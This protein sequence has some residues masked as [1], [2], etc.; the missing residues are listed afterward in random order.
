MSDQ[1]LI[2]VLDMNGN[3]SAFN[4]SDVLFFWQKSARNI[5]RPCTQVVYSSPIRKHALGE[6]VPL[7]SMASRIQK[8]GMLEGLIERGWHISHSQA[9][10]VAP[11]L[12]D[13]Q[14]L[15]SDAVPEMKFVTLHRAYTAARVD[16]RVILP[17]PTELT[18][19]F[20]ALWEFDADPP[21]S[22]IS[23]GNLTEYDLLADDA[24]YEEH[25]QNFPKRRRHAAGG[26]GDTC[27]FPQTWLGTYGHYGIQLIESLERIAEKIKAVSATSL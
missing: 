21:R 24:A 9:L 25:R 4:V 20:T 15:I 14:K 10:D 22:D 16:N 5:F 26:G 17:C 23:G 2:A 6:I 19:A 27:G 1:K 8:I 12:D 3:P 11:S 18:K 7:T 13:M